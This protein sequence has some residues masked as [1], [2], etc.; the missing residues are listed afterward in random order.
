MYHILQFLLLIIQKNFISTD[1]SSNKKH[2]VIFEKFEEE[3]INIVM[4]I[5]INNK[6]SNLMAQ[7]KIRPCCPF[8]ET[9]HNV[10]FASLGRWH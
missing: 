1:K 7:L 10:S 8:S 9:E 5:T 6:H 3:M 4:V 2:Y